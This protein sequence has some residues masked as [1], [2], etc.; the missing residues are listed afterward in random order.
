MYLKIIKKV[1]QANGPS[2]SDLNS[3]CQIGF[4]GKAGSVAV[5]GYG[6]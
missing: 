1:R 4:I 2:Q 6:N 5:A 3:K